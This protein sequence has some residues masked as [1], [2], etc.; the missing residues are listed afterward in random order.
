ML[1][2]AACAR[3]HGKSLGRMHVHAQVMHVYRGAAVTQ[4]EREN[5][6]QLSHAVH[7]ELCV[8]AA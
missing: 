7:T 6:K 8:A 1:C 5:I 3:V 2:L 4:R